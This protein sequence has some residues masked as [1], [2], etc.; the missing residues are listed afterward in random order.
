MK[1]QIGTVEVTDDE[2]RAISRFYESNGLA[3]RKDVKA[4]A[5]RAF[6]DALDLLTGE[7]EM[8]DPDDE[9]RGLVGSSSGED[10]GTEDG[11]DFGGLFE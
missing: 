1:V 7:S 3:S 8:E 5:T 2:R 9:L 10:P 6:E 11:G 4:F